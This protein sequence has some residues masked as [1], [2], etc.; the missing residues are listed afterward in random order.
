MRAGIKQI[1][2]EFKQKLPSGVR[3]QIVEIRCFGSYARGDEQPDSDLDLLIVLKA[4]DK[5]IQESINET[6][7]NIMWA[8]DFKPLLAIK[9]FSETHYKELAQIGSFFYQNLEQDG[10][11]I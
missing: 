10:V 6:A 2:D 1:L 5:G 7:Y 4:E 9:I 8:H 11:L 3:E